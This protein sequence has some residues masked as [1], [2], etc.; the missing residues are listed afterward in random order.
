MNWR[1]DSR[2]L[3]FI[4]CHSGAWYL[5]IIVI[6]AFVEGR[7]M[8]P[9]FLTWIWAWY[10]IIVIINAVIYYCQPIIA[11]SKFQV[12]KNVERKSTGGMLWVPTNIYLLCLPIWCRHK[13]GK[14][15]ESLLSLLSVTGNF[16]LSYRLP[17][18]SVFLW[19]VGFS[20][21]PFP[22]AASYGAIHGFY[23]HSKSKWL[24]SLASRVDDLTTKARSSHSL[25]TSRASKPAS[26]SPCA[27]AS[28]H[29]EHCY[30]NQRCLS[31]T[32]SKLKNKAW[33]LN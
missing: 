25:C 27:M 12:I 9:L 17:A 29:A 14:W 22:Y 33:H 4:T 19:S 30:G 2:Y 7:S 26:A 10:L 24:Q 16:E 6:N 20:R 13:E 28:E 21:H 8:V 11:L 3:R 15:Q 18:L 23:M 5:L 1:Y 31:S 32:I